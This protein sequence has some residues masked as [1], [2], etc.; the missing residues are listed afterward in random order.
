MTPS[1]VVLDD[2]TSIQYKLGSSDV[3]FAFSIYGDFEVGDQ[4]VLICEAA[5]N[6]M[7]ETSYT[8]IDYVEY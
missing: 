8:V 2:D 5:S 3:Q 6:S 1:T 7:G 4:V